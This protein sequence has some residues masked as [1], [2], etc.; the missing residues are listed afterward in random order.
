MKEMFIEK[1]YA[2]FAENFDSSN[3]TMGKGYENYLKKLMACPNCGKEG[4]KCN[5]FEVMSY[6]DFCPYEK[7]E[8]CKGCESKGVPV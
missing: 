2:E 1:D 7:G 4:R 3:A 5:C 6:C 8:I